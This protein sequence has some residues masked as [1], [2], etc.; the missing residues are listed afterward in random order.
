MEQQASVDADIKHIPVKE[1]G[2]GFSKTSSYSN[3]LIM[4]QS[5]D[6]C[7]RVSNEQIAEN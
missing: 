5:C 4:K 2:R 6:D 7:F 3:Y 1:A